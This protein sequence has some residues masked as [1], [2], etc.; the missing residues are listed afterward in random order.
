MAEKLIGNLITGQHEVPKPGLALKQILTRATIIIAVVSIAGFLVWKFINIREEHRVSAFFDQLSQGQ[1][2]QA[3]A[4]WD[5]GASYKMKDFMDDW[6]KDGF[7]TK[8]M[9]SARVVTSKGQGNGV[10]VCVDIAKNRAEV[11]IRVDKDSMKLS[12]SP[13]DKCN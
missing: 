6:G 1:Y 10:I 2:D 8:G 5:A 3:Y 4:S 11:P 7:Y 13:V 12:Y 9:Q